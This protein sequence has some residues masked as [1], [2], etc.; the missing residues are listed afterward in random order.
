MPTMLGFFNEKAL[1]F[2]RKKTRDIIAKKL[3]E[4]SIEVSFLYFP[5]HLLKKYKSNYKLN[6]SV[7]IYN[8]SILLPLH[9]SLKDT[10]L[11]KIIKIISE[12]LTN[13]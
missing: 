7:K 12:N 3:S 5:N 10:H 13:G 6:L 4:S 2:D 11:K 9:M 8:N 1:T